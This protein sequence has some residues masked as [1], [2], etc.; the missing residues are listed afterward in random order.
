MPMTPNLVN[1]RN[2]INATFPNRDKKSDGGRGDDAH[3]KRRSGHNED[4]NPNSLPTWNG[5]NDN[6]REWRAFDC[7]ADLNDPDVDSQNLVDHIRKLSGVGKVI[8]FI[9]HRA[10]IYQTSNG[11]TPENYS[12]DNL[13]Y[14]H[15][16]FEGQYTDAA[17][18]NDTFDFK[19]GDLFMLNDA[20]KKW[21]KDTIDAAATAAAKRVW[22][23]RLDIETGPEKVYMASAGSIL[24]H[25]PGEHTRIENAV[26]Q[27]KA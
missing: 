18:N 1:L 10:K 11:F 25:I 19:L 17:D 23:T 26:S 7:D 8:R 14:E 9:I 27:K 2:Q 3:Q 21:L 16:H 13:H 6:I 4:D 5:D 20:D 12:G 22:D 15:I 24:A